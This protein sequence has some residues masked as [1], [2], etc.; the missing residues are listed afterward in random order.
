MIEVENLSKNYGPRTAIKGLHFSIKKGEIVGF[1]GP[2][3]AG[4]TTTM[5]II[6][7]FMPATQGTVRV[8]GLDVF[9]QP[10]AVKKKIGYLPE[11]PP[12]YGD[13]KVE[14]YLKFVAAI[15]GVPR[16]KLKEK[17]AKA[18][19]KV[20][21][22][23]VQ[24][25]LI[26]NLSKGFRQRVG[27]A[28]A[29]VSDPEVLILDEPTVGL[30]PKQVA[31]MRKLIL[32]LKGHHTV[33]LSTHILPEVQASCEKVIIINKGEIVAQDNI[34]GLAQKISQSKGSRIVV[35]VKKVH[36]ELLQSLRNLQGVQEAS[37]LSEKKDGF[38]I[39]GNHFHE[40]HELVETIA[41]HVIQSGAGLIEIRPDSIN[42]EN[43]FIQLTST[44]LTANQLTPTTTNPSS[45]SR[46]SHH[47]SRSNHCKKEL[48]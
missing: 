37:F 36:N 21:L 25:R 13:M 39:Y 9:E 44:Q 26:Q 24:K 45:H 18:I 16:P 8:D 27:L 35:K 47:S 31:H 43:I 30:D 20:Q 19:Q 12:V 28:Q 3:G 33:I 2:N 1:L 32:G 38:L 41:Q 17:V 4:K 10:L 15:R 48:P 23:E 42:L 14:E 34:W 11:I 6:T 29:L 40:N 5:K 46:D 7:G 22:E